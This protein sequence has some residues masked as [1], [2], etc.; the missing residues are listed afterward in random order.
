MHQGTAELEADQKQL[1]EMPDF[2]RN[3]VISGVD[4]LPIEQQNLAHAAAVIASQSHAIPIEMVLHM[5]GYKQLEDG[6]PFLDL[7]KKNGMLIDKG[8]HE[9][10][11][12]YGLNQRAIYETLTRM[13]RQRL[14]D[15]AAQYLQGLDNADEHVFL[16]VEHLA[17]SGKVMSAI[18]LI[19]RAAEVAEQ[20]EDYESAIEFYERALALF[21]NDR[22]LQVKMGQLVQKVAQ[23]VSRN[24]IEN[25]TDAPKPKTKRPRKKVDPLS[26]T[27]VVRTVLGDEEPKTDEKKEDNQP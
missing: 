3:V 27:A 7:L 26:V 1:N 24:P 5:A 17:K 9:L 20:Q 14:H 10:H 13:Q 23:F 8:K 4:R 15:A 25:R 22:S 16:I 6:K 12:R 2:V 19:E 11:F 18:E 21:P